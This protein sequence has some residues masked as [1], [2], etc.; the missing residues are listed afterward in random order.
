MLK[1]GI[2]LRK[3]VCYAMDSDGS[4]MG[5]PKKMFLIAASADL[6]SAMRSGQRPCLKININFSS[7]K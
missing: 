4:H 1:E 2:L 6:F 5:S 7:G 3:L